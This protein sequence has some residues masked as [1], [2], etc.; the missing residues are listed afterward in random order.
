MET[1][2]THFSELP[3][4]ESDRIRA[5]HCRGLQEADGVEV[6]IE[7][8]MLGIWRHEAIGPLAG[9]DDAVSIDDHHRIGDDRAT[10]SID[11]ICT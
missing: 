7:L 11:Q 1:T 5:R 3:T 4:P 8:P 9:V 6:E 10:G 2:L